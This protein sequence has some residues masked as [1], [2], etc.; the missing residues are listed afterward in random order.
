MDADATSSHSG[1]PAPCALEPGLSSLFSV[2]TSVL[3]G[4][5]LLALPFLCKLP[6]TLCHTPFNYHNV[7]QKNTLL[8]GVFIKSSFM[9]PI[10]HV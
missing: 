3:L 9:F 8:F 7:E 5:S 2:C 10:F 1:V 4:P 6:T